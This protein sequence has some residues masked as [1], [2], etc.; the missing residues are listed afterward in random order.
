LESLTL[1]IALSID[2]QYKITSQKR[3]LQ[4]FI[5]GVSDKSFDS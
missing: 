4:A 2:K 1:A 5:A 3:E